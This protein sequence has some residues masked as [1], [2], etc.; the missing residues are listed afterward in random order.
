MDKLSL[1]LVQRNGKRTDG[2]F[3][4]KV[5]VKV[6]NQTVQSYFLPHQ[7][8]LEGEIGL[9]FFCLQFCCLVE[10]N[11]NSVL[12]HKYG[13]QNFHTSLKQCWCK[14]TGLF[15]APTHVILVSIFAKIDWRCQCKDRCY[16][17]SQKNPDQFPFQAKWWA[18]FIILHWFY[19]GRWW[20]EVRYMTCY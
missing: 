9:F 3:L 18:I 13:K 7:T 14:T 10:I 11:Y 6:W 16:H 17:L 12:P 4:T 19:K 20:E 1:S 8:K 5:Q 15:L 2:G